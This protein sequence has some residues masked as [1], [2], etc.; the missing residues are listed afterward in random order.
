G[1]HEDCSF[2]DNGIDD[3]QVN[4]ASPQVNTGG[5]ELN[6]ATPEGLMGL[7]PTSEDT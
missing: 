7:I 6:T 5:R 3:H 2:Q 1:T 4:T